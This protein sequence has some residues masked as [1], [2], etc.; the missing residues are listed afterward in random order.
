MSL[1]DFEIEQSAN[2][3]CLFDI[4]KEKEDVRY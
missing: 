4:S 2:D 1:R 3:S